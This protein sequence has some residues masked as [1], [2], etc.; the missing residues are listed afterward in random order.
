MRTL[1]IPIACSMMLLAGCH[2][3]QGGAGRSESRWTDSITCSNCAGKQADALEWFKNLEGR[4]VSDEPMP[5]S[6][7]GSKLTIN[8]HVV[9]GGTAVCETLF[10]GSPHEMITMY[11]MH[12]GRLVATHYCAMGNQPRMIGA[13]CLKDRA[14]HFN[15]VDATNA[16][17][18]TDECMGKMDYVFV[19]NDTIKTNWYHLKARV[20]QGTMTFT[21]R[22]QR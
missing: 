15:L 22:R 3:N 7:D 21:F 14:A 13:A 19:D 6:K 8:Y 10:P 2:I 20:P 1:L 16:N 11:H 18:D 9:G 12:F 4:W 17:P 5:E